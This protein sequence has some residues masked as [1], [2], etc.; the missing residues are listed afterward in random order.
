MKWLA[1]I[2]C[3]S[4][5]RLTGLILIAALSLVGSASAVTPP[6]A[7]PT[8][9]GAWRQLGAA[10]TSGAGK[11]L[12]FYRTALNPQRLGFVAASSSTRAIHVFWSSYC[13]IG[14]DDVMIDEHQG[15]L[16][17][18]GRVVGYPP[19]L[20]GATRCYVWVNTRVPGT[21]KNPSRAKV[22]AAEFVY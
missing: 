13:E 7:P 3:V 10:V 9:P 19:V 12:H 15:T 14:S 22:T 4:S 18:V 5:V 17:G 11:A 8:A 21:K 2:M 16:T 6:V 1:A 20:V